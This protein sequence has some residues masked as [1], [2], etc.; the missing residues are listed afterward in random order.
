MNPS[1]PEGQ[2]SAQAGFPPFKKRVYG[3]RLGRPMHAAR[4]KT[5]ETI[6]PQLEIPRDVL[7]EDGTINPRSL[8][9]HIAGAA[10]IHFEIG[11]GSGEHLHY[12]MKEFPHD[13]FIGAEPYING[14]TAFLKEFE[15]PPN[16]LRVHMDDALMVLN[17]LQDHSVDCLYILNPDPWPKSRHHKRRIVSEENLKVFARVL[18]PGGMMLQTTDVDDLAEWMLA[19]TLQNPDFEWLAETPADWVTPPNGW[20]ATRYETKGKQ[21]GR[22]QKYLAF[23]RI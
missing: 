9:P 22:V 20:M 10:K 1:E 8:T 16:N 14:M 2:G 21:A 19:L 15:T 13:I 7:R 6:L 5:L 11:F 18:K 4:L 3:R 17:S 12:L 23:K